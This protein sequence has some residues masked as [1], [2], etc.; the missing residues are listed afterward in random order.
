MEPNEQLA[1]M[2]GLHF[3]LKCQSLAS[4]YFFEIIN[5]TIK[6]VFAIVLA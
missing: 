5:G 2:F 4:D 3:I 6:T 1:R